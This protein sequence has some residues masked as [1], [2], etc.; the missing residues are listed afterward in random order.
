MSLTMQTISVMT[1]NSSQLTCTIPAEHVY[2]FIIHRSVREWK[3]KQNGE[4]TRYSKKHIVTHLL[5][6]AQVGTFPDYD[7]ALKFTRK[8]KSKPI[9]L[10][11]TYDL[12]MQHPDIGETS[13]LVRRLKSKFGAE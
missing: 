4:R 9:W 7:S 8:I 3:E 5:S 6:G 13:I 1:H 2:P 11:P 10:M 12:I